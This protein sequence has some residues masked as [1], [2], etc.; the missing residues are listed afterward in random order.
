MRSYVTVI[1]FVVACAS[2]AA[3]SDPAFASVRDRLTAEPTRLF[4]AAQPAAGTIDARRYTHDGWQDGTTSVSITNGELV[5]QLDA[6]GKLAASTFALAIDPIAIP[7]EVF[8]K[9][10]QL[11]DVRVTL[12]TAAHGDVQWSDADDATATLALD[13]DLAWSLVIAGQKTPLGAQHLPTI[14][15]DITLAGAGDH[16]DASLALHG[17]GQ[18]W[19]WADLVQ[20]RDLELAVTAATVDN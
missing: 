3:P 18:L 9:P 1:P 12:T 14:P 7:D 11:D 10:A 13:L 8:G 4:A 5:A 20:L 16:V 19:S 17:D 2:P 6:S 15:V